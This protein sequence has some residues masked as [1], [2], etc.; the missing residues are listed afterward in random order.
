M[1]VMSGDWSHGAAIVNV[2][3]LGESCNCSK[4]QARKENAY[5]LKVHEKE[6]D[7]LVMYTKTAFFPTWK[8][9]VTLVL[10]NQK[11]SDPKGKSPEKIAV[12]MKW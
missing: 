2:M 4:Q 1:L 9:Q 11:L 5:L 8:N 12:T 10:L 6:N 7:V 3:G